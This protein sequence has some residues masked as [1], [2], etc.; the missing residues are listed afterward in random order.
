MYAGVPAP[1]IADRDFLR[2][3]GEAEVGDAYLTAAVC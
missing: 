3:R 2:K 1:Q